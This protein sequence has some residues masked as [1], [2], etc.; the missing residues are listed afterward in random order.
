MCLGYNFY[1]H[2][3]LIF[4][5]LLFGLRAFTWECI[6]NPT[7]IKVNNYCS[8]K[9]SQ[10][11]EV[12]FKE[13]TVG[14]HTFSSLKAPQ[15]Y[16]ALYDI[17]CGM[18]SKLVAVVGDVFWDCVQPQ[19][20]AGIAIEEPEPLEDIIIREV[21]KSAMGA[22]GEFLKLGTSEEK[23]PPDGMPSSTKGIPYN[24]TPAF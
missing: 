12:Y 23:K 16:Q 7:P 17:K 15:T 11:G 3:I 1:R 9:R 6:V 8:E 14:K 4:K 5:L 10:S 19:G 18:N 24:S 22:F 21:F 2:M 20:I 13:I